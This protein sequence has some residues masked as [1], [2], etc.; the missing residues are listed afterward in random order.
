MKWI[1]ACSNRTGST[2]L[3]G[4]FEKSYADMSAFDEA[5]TARDVTAKNLEAAGRPPFIKYMRK[6]RYTHSLWYWYKHHVDKTA[7]KDIT[8]IVDKEILA[9]WLEWLYSQNKHVCF[10][11]LWNHIVIFPFIVDVINNM[12]IKVLYLTRDPLQRAISY[13]NKFKSQKSHNQLIEEF[14]KEAEDLVRWFPKHLK[15]TYEELTSD[16]DVKMLNGA[17][18]I[19]SYLE[20]YEY[21][22][23]ELFT[24][25]PK[26]NYG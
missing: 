18:K 15:I 5:C 8:N 14:N 4:A 25:F 24:A 10:K 3:N 13:K 16:R 7:P 23:P 11:L 26:E 21:A 19:F 12:D 2:M 1:I 22:F 9:K 17:T 20:I 6:H